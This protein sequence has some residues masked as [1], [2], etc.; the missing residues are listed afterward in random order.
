[1][2]GSS[3]DTYNQYVCILLLFGSRYFA[4]SFYYYMRLIVNGSQ[5]L[6]KKKYDVNAE[7]NDSVQQCFCTPSTEAPH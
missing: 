1:M 6:C 4:F 2:Y 3:G 7:K 5:I